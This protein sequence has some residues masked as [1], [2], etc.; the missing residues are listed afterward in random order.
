[1]PSSAALRVK[2]DHRAA[3][4][5]ELLQ[6]SAQ[7]L[8]IIHWMVRSTVRTRSLAGAEGENVV[9]PRAARAEAGRLVMEQADAVR[10]QKL[11]VVLL[12]SADAPYS[13]ET[14]P[15]TCANAS[16]C[17]YERRRPSG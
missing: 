4:G 7:F 15:V 3:Y 9:R 2:D 6:S 10:R 16:P 5:L 8:L 12:N 11:V 17:G 13:G 14:K 1:M